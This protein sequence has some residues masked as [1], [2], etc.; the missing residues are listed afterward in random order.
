MRLPLDTH[1]ALWMFAGSQEISAAL[2]QDLTDLANELFFSDA[3]AWEIVIKHALGKLPLPPP[4]NDFVPAMVAQHGMARLPISLEA[5]Y[6]WGK[7]PMIH[8]DPFDRLLVAQAIREGCS[9]V[10]CDP[11]IRKYQ[12]AIHW[13]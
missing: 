5:I 10:S 8:R 2:Q 12:V 13:K 6:E 4:P 3:S 7:L 11:E 1:S 9:L